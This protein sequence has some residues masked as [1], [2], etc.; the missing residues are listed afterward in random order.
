MAAKNNSVSGT[1]RTNYY[2]VSYGALSTRVKELPEGYTE[3]KNDELKSLSKKTAEIDL[4]NKY[5]EKTG[6]YPFSVF[7]QSIEGTVRSIS[8]KEPAGMSKMLELDMLDSDGDVS[9]ISM[10][11]YS[12]YSENLLNRLCSLDVINDK[13]LLLTPYAIPNTFNGTDGTVVNIYNQGVSV[14]AAGV[15]VELAF[16]HKNEALPKTERVQDAQGNDTTSRVK[17]INFLFDKVASKFKT[18]TV[19]SESGPVMDE[20]E[21]SDLPF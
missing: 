19:G 5:V 4:R 16:D 10:N 6:D 3:I 21:D 7:Y 18:A 20:S 17:R 15:K 12:K 1:G 14:R 8:K 13:E 9:L 2:G 11:L